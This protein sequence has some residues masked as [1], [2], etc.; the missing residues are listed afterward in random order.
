MKWFWIFPNRERVSDKVEHFYSSPYW[1]EKF[2]K[3]KVLIR[4]RRRFSLSWILRCL[5]WKHFVVIKCFI[6]H[7]TAHLCADRNLFKCNYFWTS[8]NLYLVH[9][10]IEI[11]TRDRWATNGLKLAWA[12]CES[13][14][15]RNFSFYFVASWYE[16]IKFLMWIDELF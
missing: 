15:V 9:N 2:G 4:F 12:S 11:H 8:F 16:L 5:Y 1:W 7:S 14:I 13:I 10:S 3:E 6:F